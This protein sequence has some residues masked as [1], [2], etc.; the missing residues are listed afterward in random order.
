MRIALSGCDA[1]PSY[2]L[3]SVKFDHENVYIVVLC[4]GRQHEVDIGRRSRSRL[5]A[6]K[7]SV[8]NIR[9]NCSGIFGRNRPQ[10]VRC[11]NENIN[12]YKND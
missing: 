2:A 12:C 4:M 7:W 3:F 10:I 1:N 6:A 5:D 11:C 8:K 9:S